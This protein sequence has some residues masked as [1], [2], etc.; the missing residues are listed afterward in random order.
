MTDINNLKKDAG[1]TI[2]KNEVLE[3]IGKLQDE[4]WEDMQDRPTID[5][6]KTLA[7]ALDRD[8]QKVD[9][10]VDEQ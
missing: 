4:V 2:T 6:I 7:Q 10:R 5:Y 1:R 9:K 8:I 3:R